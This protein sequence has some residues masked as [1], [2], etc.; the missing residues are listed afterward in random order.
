LSKMAPF[1]TLDGPLAHF[2]KIL[3]WTLE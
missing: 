2:A 1:Y 3:D